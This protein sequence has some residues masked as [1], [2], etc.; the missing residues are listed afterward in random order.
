MAALTVAPS[1]VLSKPCDQATKEGKLTVLLDTSPVIPSQG[2][3]GPV[4]V[5][6][7]DVVASAAASSQ[8]RHVRTLDS[9]LISYLP[10]SLG[11]APLCLSPP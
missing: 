3:G 1:V 8:P 11:Q 2:V 6:L 4:A 10:D 5:E 9:S 7:P